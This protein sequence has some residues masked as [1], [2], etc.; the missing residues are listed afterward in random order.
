MSDATICLNCTLPICD[1]SLRECAYQNAKEERTVPIKIAVPVHVRKRR[2]QWAASA[3]RRRAKGL[4]KKSQPLTRKGR[5]R[6]VMELMKERRQKNLE[7][8]S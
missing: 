7:A 4:I 6:E 5:R 2:E 3:S 8:V 1:E